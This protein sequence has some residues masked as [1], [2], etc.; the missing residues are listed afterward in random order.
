MSTQLYDIDAEAGLIGAVII[1]P[2]ILSNSAV[3]YI[4]TQHFYDAKN[5]AI[6]EHIKSCYINNAPIDIIEIASSLKDVDIVYLNGVMNSCSSFTNADTYAQIVV[7]KAKRRYTEYEIKRIGK[8]IYSD[9]GDFSEQLEKSSH[10]FDR[11]LSGGNAD[12]EQDEITEANYP[13]L[14]EN[15]LLPVA[16]GEGAGGWLYRYVAFAENVSPMTPQSFHESAGLWLA[17][18]AIARRL[19]VRMP[20]AD[21]YPNLF[22]LWVA[23]TTLYRKTTALDVARDIVNDAM[24]HLMAAQDTTPEAFLSDLAGREPSYSDKMTTNDVAEW[25]KA[26]NFCAQRGW[27]LDEMSG[28]LAS[29]G[30]EYNAGLL[31]SL[32]KFY[33]CEKV[34]KR[35]TRGQGIVT[36]RNSSLS[37]M[38][39]T[40]PAAVSHHITSD[41]LWAMGFWPRFGILTPDGR[42]EWR[43]PGNR[44]TNSNLI[45]EIELLYNSFEIPEYPDPPQPK[46]VALADGVYNAW[47]AYNKAMSFDMLS[48][49]AI[50]A[51]LYGAYGRMPVQCIKIAIILAALDNVEY[52]D[53][54]TIDLP[55]LS[56]AQHICEEWRRSAHRVLNV[57]NEN[58]FDRM[59][60]RILGEIAKTKGKG[61][62]LRDLYK[63]LRIEPYEV[64]TVLSQMYSIGEIKSFETTGRGRP[65]KKYCIVTN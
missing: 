29:A 61:A 12:D 65:T 11:I 50:D 25:K 9:N 63:A 56:R 60:I 30:R 1:A 48:S 62:T 32:L 19:V 15:T 59:R 2:D 36:I 6:W 37:M 3:R 40:T 33:D 17:A 31:E 51:R 23:E 35:S 34:Y 22:V 49:G 52:G 18:V 42:P 38:G 58:N 45:H 55:H 44:E 57:A 43:E 4:R 8:A 53:N 27:V 14:P 13:E 7:D 24:P 41:R 16:M 64:E 39:A 28:L 54:F 26:R 10:I 5:R 20:F 21:I 47:Q 46:S